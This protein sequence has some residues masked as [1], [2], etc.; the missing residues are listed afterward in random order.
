MFFEPLKPKKSTKNEFHFSRTI[1]TDLHFW[2]TDTRSKHGSFF[3]T[4]LSSTRRNPQRMEMKFHLR[5]EIGVDGYFWIF[6]GT[7]AKNDCVLF[8]P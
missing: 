4:P 6:W 8:K 7:E 2:G 5:W 3:S 1:E